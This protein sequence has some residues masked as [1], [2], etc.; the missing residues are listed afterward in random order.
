MY[1]RIRSESRVSSQLPLSQAATLLIL[2]ALFSP[3]AWAQVEGPRF[4]KDRFIVT[5]K[6]EAGDPDQFSERLARAHGFGLRNVYRYALQGMVIDLPEPAQQ[7]VLDALR[8]NPNVESIVQDRTITLT[9]QTSPKG[10]MRVGAEGIH[11]EVEQ[12]IQE[13]LALQRTDGDVR[14]D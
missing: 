6:T 10:L 14:H 5:F 11:L 1:G 3:V 9:A 2:A 8:Q 12:R 4:I 7:H 13:F